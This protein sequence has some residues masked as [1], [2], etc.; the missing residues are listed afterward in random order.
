[1]AQAGG[2]GSAYVVDLNTGQALFASAAGVAR[3]PAS[4][5]KLY[6]TT[7][8]LLRLGPAATFTTS[9][10]GR[11]YRGR[12]GAWVGTLYL[13]GGGD[14]TFGS[15]GF[16]QFAYG[17]GA[18]VQRLVGT[19]LRNTHITALKGRVIGDQSYFD[20]LP[21]TSE[22]NYRFDPY[23]EGSL[24][25]LAYNRGLLNGGSAYVTNPADYAAQQF[26]AALQAA[27]VRVPRRR[28]TGAGA[29]PASV[30]PLAVVHSPSIAKLIAMTN[31][32][33]DNFF[34]ETMLKDLGAQFGGAGTTAAGA[35]VVRHEL[36]SEFGIHPTLVDGSGLSRQDSTS[37]R[38][39]VKLLSQMAPNPY[40]VNSLA[41][42]GE[43]GTLQGEMLGTA[44]QGNCRGKTGT[45]N[46]VA[47]LAGYCHGQDGHTLAF[48]YMLNSVSDP[49]YA[50]SVEANM[51]A[52]LANY[53][54]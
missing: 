6:T 2:A 16:D 7:T 54:G 26:T 17:A 30:R 23:M 53:D 39:V 24:S 40:F 1:M 25:A 44:A 36:A 38:D 8:A 28:A 35:A 3:L 13:R 9:V 15:A 4:V 33:S 48:A 20:S 21:G 46:D 37:P 31:T 47:A 19:L 18:T 41:V 45:L 34:A 11:G 32:P 29:A 27:R 51:A 42:G 50:H 43:T 49:S 12:L 52:A 14:P 22:S 5:E 10:L